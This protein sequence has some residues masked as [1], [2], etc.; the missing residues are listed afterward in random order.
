MSVQRQSFSTT[1]K[2]RYCLNPGSEKETYH[3]VLDLNNAEIQYAVGDCLGIYPENE[4]SFV[5]KLIRQWNVAGNETVEDRQGNCYPLATFLTQHANLT[6]IPLIE[7]NSNFSTFCLSTLCKSLPPLLPRFYSIASSMRVVGK[8]AHLII[9]LIDGV[10]TDFLCKRAP[11]N[12]Q[13]LSVFH[14]PARNFCLPPESLDKPIIMIG[15]GTGV[16]PF[17]GFM[18]ERTAAA[19]SPKNWLFFGEK[20]SQT[21]FYYQNDWEDLVAQGKLTLDCA[22]SRDQAD[23]VYVQHKMLEKSRQFWEW[24]QEGAYLF[25]CGDAA[26]MAKDVDRTLLMIAEKEGGLSPE[27]SKAY[28][29]DL[30]KTCR[31]QRDVY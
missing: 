8:E 25:V 24:L 27:C 22:F 18:Q 21:D 17:R 30:K 3:L 11:L 12:Q 5:K 19:A 9:G 23:K 31:Y 26:R 4:P 16:A 6:R 14:H 13:L 29:K 20:K 2:Q 28:I 10:C 15:P 7:Q 1:I